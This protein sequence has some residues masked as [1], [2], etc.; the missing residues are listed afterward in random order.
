LEWREIPAP[1]KRCELPVPPEQK[2]K[3]ATPKRKWV[4]PADHPWRKAIRRAVEQAVR[5]EERKKGGCYGST[6]LGIV[7]PRRS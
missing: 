5:G 7:A 1:A 3:G 6:E 4:P 2:L